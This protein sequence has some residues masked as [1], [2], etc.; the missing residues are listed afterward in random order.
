MADEKE[1]VWLTTED[2]PYNPFESFEEWY[3]Q[4]QLLAIQQ[5]RPTILSYID[6]IAHFSSAM[7]DEMADRA[8]RS[9]IDEIVEFNVTGLYK[10]VTESEA[11]VLI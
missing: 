6:R 2:N 8:W 4:D 3:S 9:A 10:K 1:D 11:R 5:E 7:T